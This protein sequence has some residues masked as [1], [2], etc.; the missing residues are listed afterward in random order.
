MEKDSDQSTTRF[1]HWS[2]VLYLC[3]EGGPTVVFHNDEVVSVQ[4]WIGR[5]LLFP[6]DRVHGVLFDPARE[7]TVSRSAT[8]SSMSH[9]RVSDS[10]K[11]A[12]CLFV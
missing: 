8:L 6:G 2:S 12:V 4:P 10:E 11:E 7:V 5:Y 9:V 3:Q 1:P